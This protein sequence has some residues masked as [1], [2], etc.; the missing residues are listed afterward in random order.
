M[1]TKE[2]IRHFIKRDSNPQY[3][4]MALA[5]FVFYII[6][7]EPS[8]IALAA[9][10]IFA[11]F[12]V[13]GHNYLVKAIEYLSEGEKSVEYQL[14]APSYRVIQFIFQVLLSVLLFVIAGYKAPLLFLLCWWV[15]ACDAMYYYIL[16]ANYKQHKDMTWLRWTAYG[17]VLTALHKPIK[18][19]WIDIGYFT[20]GVIIILGF[21]I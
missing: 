15:G 17:I 5:M 9:L 10:F 8:V 20:G 14:A 3:I 7:P 19:V 12:D 4:I 6:D 18:P 2:I 21:F 1:T 13:Y 11:V 16:G